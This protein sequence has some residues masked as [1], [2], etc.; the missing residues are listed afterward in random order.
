MRRTDGVACDIHRD[1]EGVESE[2]DLRPHLGGVL[3]D[4]GSEGDDVSATEHGQVGPDVLAHPVAV[5]LQGQRGIGVPGTDQGGQI[6]EVVHA[7]KA[8]QPRPAVQESVQLIHVQTAGPQQVQECAGVEIAAAGTH[9]ETF[10][11]RQTHRRLHRDPAADGR[12]RRTVTQ[13]EHDLVQLC[14]VPTERDCHLLGDVLVRGAVEAV[15]PNLV[16][17]SHFPVDG[18]GVGR[19]RQGPEERRVEHRNLGNT[20]ERNPGLLDTRCV[21][22]IVQ[23]SQRRQIPDLLQDLIID[24]D[25][26]AEDRPPV[27]D[28]MPHRGQRIGPQ[29]PARV[30][31]QLLH[32]AQSGGMVGNLAV[33]DGLVAGEPMGGFGLRPADPLDQSTGHRLGLV[34][35]HQLVLH[36]R[37]TRVD[38]QH[39][40]FHTFAPDGEPW[41]WIAVI[42][43]VFTMSA[44]VAPRERSFTGLF[45]P[46]STGPMATAPALRW[47]AL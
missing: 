44:T 3:P 5:D 16:L 41:A 7:G 6:T 47:T 15:S 37:R 18:I 29:R 14:D 35:V 34:D 40:D 32:H 4:P 46:C 36:R 33:E 20:W 21:G 45:S 10:Q 23:W 30:D 13:V 24:Q 43:T 19:R 22:R 28:P 1:P 9:H 38:H 8:Q 27:D 26:V 12:Y 39:G 42:A 31:E 2:Q 17:S 11:R 25:R